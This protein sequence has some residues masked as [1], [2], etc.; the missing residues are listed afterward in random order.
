MNNYEGYE[1]YER[2]K[3][4]FPYRKLVTILSFISFISGKDNIRK[5]VICAS[6]T[7]HLDSV[8]DTFRLQKLY[9]YESQ[10]SD[11]QICRTHVKIIT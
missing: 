1:R 2:T 7:I 8:N 4:D 9:V 11:S 6:Q 3:S 5:Y 10:F